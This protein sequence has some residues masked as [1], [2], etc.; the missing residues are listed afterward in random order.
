MKAKKTVLLAILDGFGIAK[1]SS[2]NAVSQADMQHFKYLQ[3]NYPSFEINASGEWVGLP[4][5]QMGN[6]EVGHLHLGSGRIFHQS[7]SL[8][9]N[10]IKDQSFY[11]NYAL[12][13]AI[14]QAKKNKSRLHIIGLLS[15][16]GVHSH[17]NHVLAILDIAK[18]HEFRD[19]YIHAIL[20][21]RD[22]KKD[23]AKL[24]LKKLKLKMQT[25][26]VGYLASLSGRYYAMD[27]DKRWERLQ[28]VWDVMVLHQ[29]P[30]FEDPFQYIDDEYQQSRFD[31]FIIPAFNNKV[32]NGFIKDNDSVI[33]VNF[34]PDRSIQ[35]GAALT[36]AAYLWKPE[37]RRKNLFV[38]TMTEY[39]ED[40]KPN[41]IAFLSN[42]LNDVL[43][44]WIS[45]QDLKQ[46][47]IA[48]T[49]KY[50]HVT[51]FFDGGQDTVFSGSE[52]ILISSPKVATYDLQPEM[53]APAITK[54]LVKQIATQKFDLIVLNFA[55]P[56]MVGHTGNLEA[57]ITALKVIDDCLKQIYEALKAISGIM[58]LTA[59]HGNAEIMIDKTGDINK[60]HT[61][62]LVPLI[63]TK[64]GL[65]FKNLETD[66]SLA[67]VAPTIC[68][69]LDIS[70][71][72]AMT[73]SSIIESVMSEVDVSE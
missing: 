19:V 34:R 43:G 60:K 36:N 28:L 46:L 59:D 7:L 58:V 55:N 72:E 39:S 37:V 73:S 52:R 31:E 13:D 62:Q 2:S 29:G 15:D 45:K 49:E 51:Y 65:K 57:T 24:Y 69:L 9:N 5:G 66:I 21:G 61:S 32:K 17:L 14:L 27:R 54:E 16:G 64:Q 38:V 48:E 50:A 42:N 25:L 67:N 56:D 6:S 26:N 40:V 23:V 71:P 4:S 68:D 70:I 33:M 20:D 1:D 12:I 8:I 3:K 44:E 11:T 18:A 10:A 41:K 53:A 63:I 22:T 35:L 30:S 47:R